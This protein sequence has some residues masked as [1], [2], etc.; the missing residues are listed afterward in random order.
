MAGSQVAAPGEGTI[1]QGGYKGLWNDLDLGIT[2]DGFKINHSEQAVPIVSDLTGSAM[3]DDISTGIQMS[4]S[5]VLQHW[6]AQAIEP[7]MWWHGNSNPANYSWGSTDGP[8]QSHWLAAKPLILYACNAQG[9]AWEDTDGNTVVTDPTAPAANSANPYIDPLDIIFYK[10][11]LRKDENL[12]ILLSTTQPRFIELTLDVYP[13][14]GQ[15]DGSALNR[16]QP[17]RV[18][19]PNEC[20]RLNYFSATRG[21]SP[22][23]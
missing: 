2:L 1:I 12:E 19:R 16:N 15:F 6:N 10:T 14:S 4:V 22:S 21:A 5:M 23:A 17:D 20:G 8:G 18:E 9:F 3:Y 11:L 7:L 13:V